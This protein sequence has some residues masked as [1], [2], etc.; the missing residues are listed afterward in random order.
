LLPLAALVSALAC[1]LA[2][3]GCAE[4]GLSAAG[5]LAPVASATSG[6]GVAGTVVDA[7]LAVCPASD[8]SVAAVAG[9][10]PDVTLPCLAPGSGP[11]QVRLAG[12]R[13]HAYA[14]SVWQVACAICRQELAT[15]ATVAREAA[16]QVDFLGV[17]VEETQR[18]A[19]PALFDTAGAAFNSVSDA[20]GTT[21]V[22]LRWATGL[23]VMLLV[24]AD[25]TV[26]HTIVG[27]VGSAPALRAQLRAS[28]GVNLP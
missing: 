1:A 3:S 27:G 17:D 4:D 15:I 2:L 28:L 20:E 25:G 9:G 6:T 7:R 13:G 22:P 5:T 16:G 19:V 18:S 21:R 10:L 11:A 26:A 24:R 12:L 14:I 23:P 8:V